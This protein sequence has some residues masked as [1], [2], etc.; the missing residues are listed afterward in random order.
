MATLHY[1]F[2]LSNSDLTTGAPISEAGK[3]GFQHYTPI[4][5][6][7]YLLYGRTLSDLPP[8]VNT[9][10]HTGAYSPIVAVR[11]MLLELKQRGHRIRLHAYNLGT[12]LQPTL[13]GDQAH[14]TLE[15]HDLGLPFR[16]YDHAFTGNVISYDTATLIRDAARTLFETLLHRRKD[17][18]HLLAECVPGG[19][20]SANVLLNLFLGQTIETASSSNRPEILEARRQVVRRLTHS[21][22]DYVGRYNL[23]PYPL[24]GQH[25]KDELLLRYA[26]H[27]QLFV[28]ELAC[29]IAQLTEP[30]DQ[31]PILFGGGCQMLAPIVWAYTKAGPKPYGLAQQTLTVTTPWV[32][33]SAQVFNSNLFNA[34]VCWYPNMTHADVNFGTAK[35]PGWRK[36]EEG[37]AKEGCG[38]GAVMYATHLLLGASSND[39]VQILDA[40][41]PHVHAPV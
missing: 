10:L 16:T 21:A 25:L 17:E 8:E 32:A 26:D 19:T 1:H 37:F 38:L 41:E 36:Y 34:D 30:Q 20:L 18:Y 23:G 39:I 40:P 29:H 27:F 33:Y 4:L 5:D 11:R 28:Y 2:L 15:Y 22:R 13:R 14:F 24:W 6:L 7:E 12:G 3:P 9:A 35:D 31:S